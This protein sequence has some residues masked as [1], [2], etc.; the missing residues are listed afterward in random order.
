[1]G[2]K[3]D[4]ENIEKELDSL[5]SELQSNPGILDKS[6][7]NKPSTINSAPPIINDLSD[8]KSLQ[9]YIDSTVQ[10]TIHS[11]AQ[12]IN[13]LIQDAGDCPDKLNALSGL[14]TVKGRILSILNSRLL[15]EKEL[16]TRVELQNARL[17]NNIKEVLSKGKSIV[18]TRDEMMDYIFDKIKPADIDSD[19]IID[20]ESEKTS[21]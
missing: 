19:D 5:L 18:C 2:N 9:R 7:V 3:K 21:R 8:E 1:M 20:I 11:L 14:I 16:R 13:D 6:N 12:P 10:E 15:K 4:V 17:D